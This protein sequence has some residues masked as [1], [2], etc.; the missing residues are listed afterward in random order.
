MIYHISHERNLSGVR[1]AVR[2]HALSAGPKLVL[3]SDLLFFKR[4]DSLLGWLEEPAHPIAMRDCQESY[5]HP[6]K[7]LESIAGASLPECINVGICGFDSSTLDWNRIEHWL[8][9][10]EERGTSYYDEQALLAMILAT[11]PHSILPR[12]YVCLPSA[13]EIK[14]PT[15]TLHHYVAQAKHRYFRDAWRC[16]LGTH[17]VSGLSLEPHITAASS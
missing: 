15:A 13:E 12:Q 9:A 16:A 1:C 7:W 11:G 4:P 6:R 14:R 17:G 3:D 10:L 5:G 8:R 2:K